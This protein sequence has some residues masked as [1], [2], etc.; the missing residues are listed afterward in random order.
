MN[1]CVGY[2]ASSVLTFQTNILCVCIETAYRQTGLPTE[3]RC[4]E[5]L[6]ECSTEILLLGILIQQLLRY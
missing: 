1:K 5:E 3:D 6:L 2:F 4:V